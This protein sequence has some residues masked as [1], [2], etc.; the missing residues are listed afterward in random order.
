MVPVPLPRQNAPSK[1]AEDKV[2]SDA[3]VEAD[4]SQTSTKTSSSDSG[5]DDGKSTPTSVEDKVL[6]SSFATREI[7]DRL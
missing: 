3:T 2:G 7:V 4:P 1:H 6:F 5:I